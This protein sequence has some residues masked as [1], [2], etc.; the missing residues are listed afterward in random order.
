MGGGN[1]GMPAYGAASAGQPGYAASMP[2][3]DAAGQSANYSQ[4]GGGNGML[5]EGQAPN[6]VHELPPTANKAKW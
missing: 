1:Y 5:G 2:S 3:Q 6:Q 4:M